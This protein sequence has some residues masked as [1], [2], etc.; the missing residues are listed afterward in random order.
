MGKLDPDR[1]RFN[2]PLEPFAPGLRE[3]LARLGYAETSA[4]SLLQLAAHPVGAHPG[5]G[6]ADPAG[7]VAAR[8]GDPRCAL[9][10]HRR[11]GRALLEAADELRPTIRSAT[12]H[13]LIALMS[14]TG[15]RTGRAFGLD[16]GDFNTQTGT[17]TVTGKFGKTRMLPLH[18]TV[19]TRL[20][21]YLAVR[22]D[23]LAGGN[24]AALLINSARTTPLDRQTVAVLASTVPAGPSTS[25]EAP[26]PFHHE[27][28]RAT[29]HI[30][31]NMPHKDGGQITLSYV[32]PGR[33]LLSTGAG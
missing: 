3:E 1:V 32:S 13:T 17:L 29:L 8:A 21:E 23:H 14:A 28:R 27:P 31:K 20:A 33:G 7:E 9:P 19:T 25:H 16:L 22:A 11:R 18:E 10:L 26:H 6:R 4:A 15:I 5:P 30:E 2:G 24:C 12:F